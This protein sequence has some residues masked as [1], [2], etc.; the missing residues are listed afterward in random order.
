[1]RITQ[2]KYGFA[3]ARGNNQIIGRLNL[4]DQPQSFGLRAKPVFTCR[5]F[6]EIQR[7]SML[8]DKVFEQLM[9]FFQ[10]LLELFTRFIGVFTKHG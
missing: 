6:I 10:L 4:I 2:Q 1:M 5:D 8:T 7:G 9:C 3:L